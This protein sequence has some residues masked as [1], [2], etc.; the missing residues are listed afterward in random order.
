MA[1]TFYWYDFETFGVD[2]ARDRPVQFAGM[3]TD[4]E[5]NQIGDPLVIY[6]KPADD[7]L[8]HPQACLLTGIT[9]QVGVEKGVPEAEF[10]KRIL[11]E[12]SRPD[13]CVLGYNSLRFD[14]EVTRYTLYRNLHDPYAREWRNGNS[15][16]DI[17]DMVRL[18]FAVRP[19]GINWP[20]RE[21]G[22]ASFRL[23]ELTRQ[24]NIAH[25]GA[26]DA[27]ADVYATIELAKLLKSKQPRLYDYV[28]NHRSKQSIDKQLQLVDPKPLVHIS[29]MYG[30]GQGNIAIVLPIARDRI[31]KNAVYVYDLREDAEPLLS[32]SVE[33]LN[34]RL[35]TPRAKL[36]QSELPVSIKA[37]HL[38]R[39]PVLAP[40]NILDENTC[41]RWNLNVDQAQDRAEQLLANTSLAGRVQKA[42]EIREF[43]PISDSDLML[44]SGGFF[45][46]NDRSYMDDIRNVQPA[47]LASKVLPPFSDDRLSEMIF[48]YRARNWPETLAGDEAD[49]WA[50][51]CVARLTGQDGV[52]TISLKDYF[53]TIERFRQDK[54]LGEK[55][56]LIL[57]EL[58][59]YGRAKQAAFNIEL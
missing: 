2:P 24:N 21:D 9:P 3:R 30:A 25:E 18:A 6:C 57:V 41:R 28:F 48:R 27:L 44:Y 29:G 54:S 53:E 55:Q 39:C 50:E 42:F 37:V 14:D 1:K 12:F 52:S 51:H 10:I 7:V 26:H 13:T 8:P 56:Q 59:K 11:D 32:L 46:D 22:S 5:F 40:I 17:I 43:E 45:N 38:N 34:K 49:S 35:F 58:E 19:D 15:R 16:W 47:Q 23:E 4:L 20:L 31:N 36:A 33:Q